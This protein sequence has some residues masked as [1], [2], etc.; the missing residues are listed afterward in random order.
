MKIKRIFFNFVYWVH[1]HKY[2]GFQF[3]GFRS[4]CSST[5]TCFEFGIKIKTN[6]FYQWFLPFVFLDYPWAFLIIC[7]Y[8]S[9]VKGILL[10]FYFIFCT[11]T[12]IHISV[13]CSS[14]NVLSYW[15]F[16]SVMS[17]L[18][19]CVHFSQAHLNYWADNTRGWLIYIHSFS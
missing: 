11:I 6:I 18:F 3:Y 17:Q 13:L 9:V 12:I 4:V 2:N 19:H 7:C 10:F 1:T 8:Y 15:I 5:P 14:P 16:W